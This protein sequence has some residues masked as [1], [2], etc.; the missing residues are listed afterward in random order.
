MRP[1]NGGIGVLEPGESEDNIFSPT[2]HDVE[3]IFLCNA[4]YVGKEGTNE[5]NFSFFVWGLIV[6]SYFD[7]DIKFHGG[8]GVFSDK[9]P[10]N[11]KDVYATVNQ[12]MSVNNFQHVGRSDEL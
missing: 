11:A 4:F 6:I 10:V 5:V 3:E 1:I 7:G 12:G 9:L 2:R 8:K